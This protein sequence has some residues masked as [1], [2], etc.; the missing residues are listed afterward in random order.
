MQL[1]P[2][3]I[4]SYVAPPLWGWSVRLGTSAHWVIGRLLGEDVE[5]GGDA[6]GLEGGDQGA[7]I[8]QG[9]A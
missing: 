6:P 5:A 4:D 7:L 9:A 8:D 2:S 1:R 3:A